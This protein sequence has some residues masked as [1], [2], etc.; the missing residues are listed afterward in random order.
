MNKTPRT[1]RLQGAVLFLV[2]SLTVWGIFLAGRIS[3][4]HQFY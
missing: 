3:V 2:I 4:F 1:Y